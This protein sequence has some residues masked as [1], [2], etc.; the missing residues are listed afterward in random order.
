[1]KALFVQ[2]G[3][4]EVKTIFKYA[5]VGAVNTVIGYGT[6]F[7]SMNAGAPPFLANAIGYAVGLLISFILNSRWTFRSQGSKCTSISSFFVAFIVAYGLNL[8][9]LG[10]SLAA[11]WASEYGQAASVVVYQI[12]FFVLLRTTVFQECTVSADAKSIPKALW[13]NYSWKMIFHCALI[14][15]AVFPF[16][17]FGA[18][19]GLRDLPNAIGRIGIGLRLVAEPESSL[20]YSLSIKLIPNMAV[21]VWGLSVGRLIGAEMAVNLFVVLSVVLF[22][23]SIQTLRRS[24][25]GESSIIVGAFSIFVIYGLPLRW[26]FINYFFASGLMIWSIGLLE[27]QIRQ[28]SRWF[29]IG[30]AALIAGMYL[31]SIFSVMLYFI[32]AGIRL[33]VHALP[34]IRSWRWRSLASLLGE[35]VPG[36]LLVIVF[37]SLGD[38]APPWEQDTNWIL[39]SKIDAIVSLVRFYDE[40]FELVAGALAS[41]SGLGLAWIFGLRIRIEHSAPLVGLVVTFMCVPFLLKGVAFADSRLP[42]TIAGL[43]LGLIEIRRMTTPHKNFARICCLLAFTS[44]L[45]KPWIALA[46]IQPELKIAHA[47]PRLFYGVPKGSIISIIVLDDNLSKIEDFHLH[48]PLLALIKKDVFF[49]EIFRNYFVNVRP[50]I[51]LPVDRRDK[52]GLEPYLSCSNITHVAIFSYQTNPPTSVAIEILAREGVL[53]V[54]RVLRS[55]NGALNDPC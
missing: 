39:E 22:Y 41:I 32:Y 1:L 27:L 14:F 24:I 53:S 51:T 17:M 15:S 25:F 26:G 9:M 5:I 6:I 20:F 50:D 45:L 11:G 36:F 3:L 47:I 35:H 10:A 8:C 29:P 42:A 4:N 34:L 44:S 13:L 18:A 43:A 52:V 48:L 37:L 40:P 19:S 46:Q 23:L 2:T 49:P 21:D 30:Q 55:T 28:Q 54:G 38:L 16:I 33:L 7:L 12:S 31:S